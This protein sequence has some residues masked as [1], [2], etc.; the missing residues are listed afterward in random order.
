LLVGDLPADDKSMERKTLEHLF[1]LAIGA[2]APSAP[3]L[4]VAL[5]HCS[6]PPLAG[7]PF[8]LP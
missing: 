6:S 3:I 5:L 4:V 8:D 7:W 2:S 1:F